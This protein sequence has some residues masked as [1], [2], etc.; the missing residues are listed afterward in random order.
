MDEVKEQ[1]RIR[2]TGFGW[3]DVHIA[4]S[5]NGRDLTGEELRYQF[6][7]IVLS[8]EGERGIPPYPKVN[9]LYRGE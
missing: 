2:D 8:V 5:N 1:I 6:I 9:F 4:W 3:N 7:D